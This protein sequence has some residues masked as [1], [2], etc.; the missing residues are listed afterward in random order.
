[1]DGPQHDARPMQIDEFDREV[2]K[3]IAAGL[4]IAA[5]VLVV[6]Y[7]LAQLIYPSPK[8]GENDRCL[9]RKDVCADPLP[10]RPHPN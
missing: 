1:M 9:V 7:L 8:P 4:S 5:V 3:A 10:T 2:Y 6:L